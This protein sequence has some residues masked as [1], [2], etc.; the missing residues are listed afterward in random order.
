MLLKSYISR[1]TLV[2]KMPLLKR[3]FWTYFLLLIFEGALRKWIVPPLSAPLLLVRDPIALAIIWEA[4]RTHKWPR[5]W[6]FVVGTLTILFLILCVVQMVVGDNI[7]FVALYGLRS[8]LLPFPVAFIMGENL[9]SEDLRKFGICTLW[10]LMPLVLL[11][12]AQYYAP[13]SSFL[14]A[15]ATE[16]T[17]QLRYAGGHLRPSATFSFTT[18]PTSFLPLAAAFIFYGIVKRQFVSKWLLWAASASLLI[19]VPVTGSRTMMV[20][21]AGQFVCVVIASM[22]GLAQLASSIKLFVALVIAGLAVS[23]LPVFSD[24]F[25]TMMLRISSASTGEG[26]VGGA[27]GSRVLDPFVQLVENGFTA[28]TWFGNGMGL[29]SNVASKLLTGSQQFLAGE[30]E[31]QRVLFELGPAFGMAFLFF[32]FLL[33]ILITAAAFSKARDREP[34]AWFLLPLTCTMLLGTLEQPTIQGFM[35]ISFGF[36]IAAL[37][38]SDQFAVGKNTRF[39]A[40]IRNPA[41]LRAS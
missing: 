26:G 18:G 21:L 29:G 19:A 11:E 10:L 14:N 30:T 25:D 13:A 24:A 38:Q 23:Q 22:F 16:G 34:L 3:L 28:D 35:V 12:I 33:V 27:L 20:L 7:W 5:Q 2:Q 1:A 31:F 40:P 17:E 32:R 9:N 39:S 8:Y 15:G 41:N 4:Y 6:S 37:K 36:S